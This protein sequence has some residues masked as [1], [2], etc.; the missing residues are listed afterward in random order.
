M[1]KIPTNHE[2]AILIAKIDTKL[3]SILENQLRAEDW[4]KNHVQDDKDSFQRLH[5][6][7]SSLKNYGTSI[8]IVASFC[9]AIFTW[10]WHKIMG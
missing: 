1:G 2:L 6:R 4:Q 7:I 10:I 5:D 3:D 8:A 9:G